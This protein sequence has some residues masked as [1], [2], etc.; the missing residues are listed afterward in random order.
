MGSNCISSRSLL[1]FLFFLGLEWL[2]Q[3]YPTLVK[4]FQEIKP[5]CIFELYNGFILFLKI[6]L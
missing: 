3:F 4:D 5:N 1:I 2:Y 6:A